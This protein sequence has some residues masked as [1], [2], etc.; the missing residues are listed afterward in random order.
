MLLTKQGFT[1]R[2]LV[3]GGT[4]KLYLN[5][6]PQPLVEYEEDPTEVLPAGRIALY[7]SK[8]IAVFDSLEVTPLEGE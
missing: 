3:Q 5:D 6:Q 4:A 7:A 8:L 2:L 1:L